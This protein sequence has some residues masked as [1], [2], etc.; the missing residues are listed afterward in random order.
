MEARK[1]KLIDLD[2]NTFKILSINAV[3]N[4]TNLKDY[5]E[6]VLNKIADDIE[7]SEL[8]TYLLKNFP[9]GQEMISNQEKKDFENWL[10]V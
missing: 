6:T 5:I 10:G 8:Y 7:D 3:K 1:R 2:E 9:E 4:G